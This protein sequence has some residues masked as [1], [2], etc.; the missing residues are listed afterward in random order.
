MT[1]A[2]FETLIGAALTLGVNGLAGDPA[3]VADHIRGKQFHF[4]LPFSAGR[5]ATRLTGG[6]EFGALKDLID[7][8]CARSGV[9]A[10]CYT[11]DPGIISCDSAYTHVTVPR[12]VSAHDIIESHAM[13]SEVLAQW[14]LKQSGIEELLKAS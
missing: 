1:P 2:R 13:L 10:P 14:G 3:A 12:A 6:Y 9:V 11:D 7:H 8:I 4:T 5:K